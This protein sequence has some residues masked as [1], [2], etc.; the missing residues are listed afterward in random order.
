MKHSPCTVAVRHHRL[1]PRA[2]AGASH[3]TPHR[4]ADFPRLRRMRL[5]TRPLGK[6]CSQDKGR[7]HLIMQRNYLKRAHRGH[8]E[9]FDKMLMIP[10]SSRKGSRTPHSLRSIYIKKNRDS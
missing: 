4:G 6:S 7:S 3:R 9:V 2:L 10:T 1:H 5:G 8:Q